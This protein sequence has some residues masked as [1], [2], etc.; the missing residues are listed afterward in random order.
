MRALPL[1]LLAVALSSP[2]PAVAASLKPWV[3]FDGSWG[4]YSM[5]D[6]NRELEDLNTG[7]KQTGLTLSQIGGG[8]GAGLSAGVDLGRGLSLGVGYDRLFASSGIEDA[9]H[10]VKFRLPANAFRGIAEYSF[11]R[12]GPFGARVG[13]AGGVVTETGSIDSLGRS[14]R[15]V[16]GRAPLFETYLTAEWW[17]QPRC[18]LF[19]TVGYRYARLS[20]VKIGG[21][22]AYNPPPDSSKY[23]LDFSGMMVRLGFR[24]P[25]TTAPGASAAAPA[26]KV[27]PWIGTSGSWSTYAMADVNRDIRHIDTDV[28]EGGK[29]THV[30]IHGGPGFGASAGLDFP[31]RLTVGV[32]Y[33]RLFASSKV[34]YSDGSL[35]YRLPAN[36]FRGFMECRLL[37]QGRFGTRLGIAGG[38]VMEADPAAIDADG[39]SPSLRVKGSGALVEAYG[40]FEWWATSRFA[41]A[42]SLSYRYAKVGEVKAN[43]RILFDPDHTRYGVDYGGLVA[44]LGLKVA[45]TD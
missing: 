18:G 11:P 45:L 32:A 12:Q 7:L 24:I 3:G 28:D 2:A 10:F 20:E 36:A 21:S 6:T 1:L 19:A 37:P 31:G 27:R 15:D 13:V 39:T 42:A 23:T 25:L 8:P 29:V 17:G 30:G 4:K 22:V 9:T 40:S 38:T 43:D 34:S 5:G 44:R 35:D 33:D 26:G 16:T 14:S 41:A